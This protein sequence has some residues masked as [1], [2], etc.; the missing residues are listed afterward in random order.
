M[1]RR[2]TDTENVSSYKRVAS[3][4]VGDPTDENKSDDRTDGLYIE[5]TGGVQFI[6][7]KK[8]ALNL[9]GALLAHADEDDVEKVTH[10]YYRSE[11]DPMTGDYDCPSCGHRAERH[12]DDESVLVCRK[13]MC[14]VSEFEAPD[15]KTGETFEEIEE[16][17]PDG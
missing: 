10:G 4:V 8:D 9:A 15:E 16:Q 11:W 14:R 1:V 17:E 3:L 13:D 12:E 5:L 2:I 7:T 6:I